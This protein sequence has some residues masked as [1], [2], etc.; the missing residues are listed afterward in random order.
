MNTYKEI[1]EFIQKNDISAWKVIVANEV[2]F[3]FGKDNK[4]Y[5]LICEW[6]FNFTIG[7]DDTSDVSAIT[8][9]IKEGLTS[10]KIS[11][12][13]L[14]SNLPRCEDYIRSRIYSHYRWLI[15]V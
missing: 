4:D 3:F 2:D 7:N 10:G 6:V 5:E 12:G 13:D 11:V 14:K 8:G 9:Y 15:D 1:L